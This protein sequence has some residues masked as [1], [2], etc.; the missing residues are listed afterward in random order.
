MTLITISGIDGSGKT[1][2]KNNIE[3]YL[4]DNGYKVLSFHA[5]EFSLANKIKKRIKGVKTEDHI[6]PIAKTS[7]SFFSILTR[8]TFLVIDIIRFNMYIKKLSKQKFDIIL[9]D[10]YFYDQ[11]IN[12]LFLEGRNDISVSPLWFRIARSVLKKPKFAFFLKT[13]PNIALG[14]DKEIEQGLEYLQKKNILF[15]TVSDGWGLK[16]INGNR[17]QQTV[18]ED[19]LRQL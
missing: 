12:I 11:I 5:I 17:D 9:S 18:T 3:K 4:L 19:I 7:A 1:T 14:R 2:Q 13:D 16:I 8:K 10:R 15:D 6:Q